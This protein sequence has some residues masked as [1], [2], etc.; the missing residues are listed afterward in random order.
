VLP[1]LTGREMMACD[2]Y[3]F[4][5]K[6]V[7]YVYPPPAFHDSPESV[8]EFI[9]LYGVSHVVTHHKE[10]LAVLGARPDVFEPV[11]TFGSRL[12]KTAYRVKHAESSRF[13][14]GS[15]TVAP[16][17]SAMAVTVD[18]PEQ[19]VVLRYHWQEDLVAEPPVELRAFDVGHDIRFI[20]VKPNGVSSFT[21]RYD[22][23]L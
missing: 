2:Y 11:F 1:A 18:D 10:A 22:P 14:R 7:A 12:K 17:I 5:P 8:L 4:S 6:R 13:Y 3:H 9:E 16:A 21:I 19:E 20:A 15:G 23:R